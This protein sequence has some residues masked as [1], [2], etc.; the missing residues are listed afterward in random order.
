MVKVFLGLG[1]NRGN[2]TENLIRA[3]NLI[4][5]NCKIKFKGVSSFYRTKPAENV[6]GGDFLNAVLSV[7]TGLPPEE[8]LVFLQTVEKKLG[9]STRKQNKARII[10]LDLL[11]YGQKIIRRKNLIIPHPRMLRREFVLQPLAEISP[12]TRHPQKRMTMNI[13]LQN[14]MKAGSRISGIASPRDS[15]PET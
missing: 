10:D 6:G 13:L 2:R 5:E 1:S 7:E 9:S 11:L 3:V 8:L 15:N 4:K 14:L 12:K